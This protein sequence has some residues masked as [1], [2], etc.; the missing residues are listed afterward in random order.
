MQGWVARLLPGAVLVATL[1]LAACGGGQGDTPRAADNHEVAGSQHD[2]S[3]ASAAS[4]A[5]GERIT[6]SGG[7]FTRVSPTELQE[8]MRQEEIVL[9]NTHVPF[10]GN[11]PG[12]D[13]S[14][15]Y[16][17]IGRNLDRLPGKDAKI[18]LYCR[19]GSMSAEAAQ[20]LVRLG[21]DDVWDLG[22]GMIAWK[23]AG[24]SLKGV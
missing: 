3:G 19:S 2:A 8:M 6:V 10:E 18:A 5:V 11:I 16:D 24:F 7:S 20:T 21:Y 14:I 4:G 23:E 15:P 1:L 9:V 13:L 12:T 22:G 17:K